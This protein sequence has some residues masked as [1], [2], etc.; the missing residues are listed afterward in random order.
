MHLQCALY[1]ST[2]RCQH[3][4]STPN[5]YL[6]STISRYIILHLDRSQDL[7]IGSHYET[8]NSVSRF[9]N[10]I[11]LPAPIFFVPLVYSGPC[12]YDVRFRRNCQC[13]STLS[14]F[15]LRCDKRS[16]LQCLP[17]SSERPPDVS[18]STGYPENQHNE[19]FP[20]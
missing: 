12:G 7:T 6:G 8:H 15:C 17:T 10:L 9:P 13:R 14:I 18:F 5:E 20:P 11:K 4:R 16:V 2:S 1:Y 3:V 19:A